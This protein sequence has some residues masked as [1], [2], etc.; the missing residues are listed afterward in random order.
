MNLQ[1][2]SDIGTKRKDNQDNYWGAIAKVNGSDC[3]ILCVCDGM[4]GLNNGG[5]ASKI[6]IDAVRE[7]FMSGV[8]FRELEQVLQ[9]A[10]SVIYDKSTNGKDGKMGTTCTIVEA[11][12]GRY[13]L[14]HIGDSRCYRIS[15]RGGFDILTNDHS[16][17]KM[18][19]LSPEKDYTM[20]KKYKNSLTRCIGV[21]PRIKVDYRE[22]SYNKGDKF[23]VCSDG[24]WHL[25]E[26]PCFRL[27]DLSNLRELVNKAMRE[28]EADNIT[29]CIISL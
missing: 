23:L 19:D 10:N 15:R 11:I 5:M 22:G 6:V 18:Y 4:G 28:G 16:A 7:G 13:R 3:G 26:K 9:H 12:D 2:V 27:E 25:F 14:L 24:M 8:P 17:I 1:C 20:W 29:C 21:K